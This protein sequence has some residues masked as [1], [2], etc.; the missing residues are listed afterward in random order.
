MGEPLGYNLRG[1]NLLWYNLRVAMTNRND[2]S[3]DNDNANANANIVGANTAA[4]AAAAAS[5]SALTSAPAVQPGQMLGTDAMAL[6]LARCA[7]QGE[8]GSGGSANSSLY[9]TAEALA[10]LPN[11]AMP[12]SALTDSRDAQL[13]EWR[14]FLSRAEAAPG[15]DALLKSDTGLVALRSGDRGLAIIPPF[16]LTAEL[17]GPGLRSGWDAAPLTQLLTQDYTVGVLLLRLGRY[18]VAV[19]EGERLLVSKTNTRYVKGKH[20]AGGTSQLRFQRI[21]EGQMRKLY[22]ETC[23]IV[24]DRFAPHIRQM[25]YILLGGDRLTLSGFMKV[26]PYLQQRRDKIIDRRL[27][28]RDPKHD[29]L[30]TVAGMLRQCRVWPIGW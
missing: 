4:G 11:F 29:T 27:N 9:L 22:D 19:F 16:P 24:Q 21:R 1:Y 12:N 17:A 5:T 13:R 20:H 2:S 25:D 15:G 18:L 7:P 14:Q 10:A 3:N 23:R 8:P 28:I 30:E 6:L 26:C